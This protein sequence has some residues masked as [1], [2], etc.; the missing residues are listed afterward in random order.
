[1]SDER[2]IK[3]E[4]EFIPDTE[5]EWG[6]DDEL[7]KKK[8]GCFLPPWLLIGGGGCLLTLILGIFGC[9]K[10]IEL[11]TV[12]IDPEQQWEKLDKVLPFDE[13]PEYIQMLAGWQLGME[14]YVLLD[15]EGGYMVSVYYFDLSDAEEARQ[16]FFDPEMQVGVMGVGER[17]D[18]VL[19]TVRIGSRDREVMRFFQSNVQIQF[20][21]EE[22]PAQ[23]GHS[24]VVDATASDDPGLL[25]VMFMA[26]D[27]Q[28]EIPD[29][30]L[31]LFFNN[32]LVD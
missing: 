6:G 27:G 14:Y 3:D 13:Q 18:E 32:F 21:G 25:V 15:V 12:A 16:A 26:M 17:E 19:S 29:R 28:L 4:V 30:D 24:A 10:V 23:S 1:M 8:R 5:L 7:P 2:E 11:I 20:G 9:V 22:Q 31:I